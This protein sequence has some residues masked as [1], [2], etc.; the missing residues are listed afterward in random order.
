[1]TR[2][3]SSLMLKWRR[4]MEAS[5]SREK[6]GFTILTYNILAQMYAKRLDMEPFSNIE[7]YEMITSW[8]YRRKRL[9]REIKSYGMANDKQQHQEMPEIICFQ[10]CDNYQKYWRKKMNNKLNMYSTYTEKRGKRNGCAT[11]WRT[12]RFVE[13][14]HLDLDLA[15]LSDLIDKGKETNYMYGRRDTANLT[16]LQCKLSSKY[17][18]IINN[19]LAWDPEYP[20]VKLSQMFYILQQAYNM[21][22]PYNSSSTVSV[23]LAGDFNS[24]PNSEVYNLIVEGQAV[25][26]T[27]K[28]LSFNSDCNIFTEASVVTSGKTSQQHGNSKKGVEQV[29]FN[30]F[31]KF[32]S[33]YR[34][35]RGNEPSFTNYNNGFSGTLDYIFTVD[36]GQQQDKSGQ[37]VCTRVL[38]TITEEQ[39]SEHK[40]L[41][42]LTFP[43]DHIP[44]VASLTW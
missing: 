40:C 5:S 37:L 18:L 38:D 16:L 32:K 4:R 14:A 41:P 33:C 7:N 28:P 35:V 3:Q 9:F 20:Q 1:M 19:H 27:A 42:S 21:I 25:V 44:L 12:D 23:V 30:P 15:N 22:Q 2:R 11:F 10:E 31:G 36:L 34:E 8:S 17:L 29:M 39:A 24:L 13:I 6:V 26:P 43:S